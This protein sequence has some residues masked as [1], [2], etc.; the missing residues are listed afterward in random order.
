[1]AEQMT[2]PQ[3]L[4]VLHQMADNAASNGRDH[5]LKDQ[6]FQQLRQAL[7]EPQEDSEDEDHGDNS[8]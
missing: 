6:A 5:R 4:E 8:D 3:A 7:S 1:M 2:N